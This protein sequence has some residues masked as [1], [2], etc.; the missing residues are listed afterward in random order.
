[1]IFKKRH[2]EKLNELTDAKEEWATIPG[3]D[4]Y[5]VSTLGHVFSFVKNDFMVGEET[6]KGYLRVGLK[7]NEGGTRKIRIHR[8]V[9]EAFLPNPEGKTQ[10]DHKNGVKVDNRLSNLRWLSNAENQIAAVQKGGRKTK[11]NQKAQYRLK[12]RQKKFAEKR[13]AEL[14]EIKERMNGNN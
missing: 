8:L 9:A 2:L 1:M 4:G 12:E 3:Y 11:S 6:D 5:L 7:K 13:E 10:V 14:A